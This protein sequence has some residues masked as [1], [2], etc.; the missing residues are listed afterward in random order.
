MVPSE[1]VVQTVSV[2]SVCQIVSFFVALKEFSRSILSI[3][4]YSSRCKIFG[5]FV[6]EA[7]LQKPELIICVMLP[8]GCGPGGFYI[9]RQNTEAGIL[10]LFLYWLNL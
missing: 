4:T 5:H 6:V 7:N 9:S 3:S 1:H 10:Q 2:W 8:R